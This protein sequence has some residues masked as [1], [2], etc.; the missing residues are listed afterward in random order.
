MA[1]V[2][3]TGALALQDVRARMAAALAPV[4]DGDPPVWQPSD[5]LDPPAL[6]LLYDDPWLTPLTM[7]CLYECRLEV[8]CV[9]SRLEPEPG[10]DMLD[11]LAVYALTR[12]DQDAYPWT[13]V[14]ASAARVFRLADIPL[15][16]SS[17]VYRVRVS[18]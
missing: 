14:T 13:L 5:S 11:A 10:F 4:A 18:L 1:A 15:L 16:F 17:L 12:I 6:M 8:R 3:G 9:A 7:G 2:N